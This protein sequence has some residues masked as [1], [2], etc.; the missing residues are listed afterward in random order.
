MKKEEDCWEGTSF[1][2]AV[3]STRALTY[4]RRR[5]RSGEQNSGTASCLTPQNYTPMAGNQEATFFPSLNQWCFRHLI[6]S[7]LDAVMALHNHK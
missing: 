6:N 7:S 5:Q 2:G 4:C 1:L 3:S